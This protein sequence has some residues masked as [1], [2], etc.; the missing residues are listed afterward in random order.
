M[1]GAGVGST[2]VVARFGAIY[3]CDTII[4]SLTDAGVGS[5]TVVASFGAWRIWIDTIVA[6]LANAGIGSAV[7]VNNTSS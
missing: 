2:T 6:S 3:G 7:I 5:A 1:V 4:A